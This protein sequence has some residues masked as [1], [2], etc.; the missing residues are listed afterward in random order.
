MAEKGGRMM[1]STM[2]PDSTLARLPECLYP[3]HPTL[4]QTCPEK[5]SSQGLPSELGRSQILTLKQ[6]PVAAFWACGSTSFERINGG[7]PGGGSAWLQYDGGL[8]IG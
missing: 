3:R 4:V 5:P 2:L 1:S 6:H 8:G 7:L